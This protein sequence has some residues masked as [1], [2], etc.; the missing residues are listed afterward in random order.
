MVKNDSR[1]YRKELVGVFAAVATLS[2]CAPSVPD[3]RYRLTVEVETPRGLRTGSSVIAVDD[4]MEYSINGGGYSLSQRARGEAVAVDLPGGRTLFA[5][6]RGA[7]GDSGWAGT[8]LFEL[9]PPPPFRPEDEESYRT[10]RVKNAAAKRNL[11]VVPPMLP[12]RDK[13]YAASAYPLLVTFTDIRDPRTVE[14]VDPDD[15]AASFGPGV[16]LK[17][18]TVQITNDSVTTG[19]LK[20]LSWLPQFHDKM[21]NGSTINNSRQL[22][23][24]LSSGDFQQGATP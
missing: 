8:L 15:L 9:T 2:G 17:R 7:N 19:M 16:R 13:L 3:Y 24:S 23:N 20:R 10:D 11:I 4:D 21:L 14:R 18:V 1:M 22:A 6:L 5:L 12:Y